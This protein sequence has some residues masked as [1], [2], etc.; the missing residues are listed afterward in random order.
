MYLPCKEFIEL[1][2]LSTI[3]NSFC[4]NECS[5]E[6]CDH[7]AWQIKFNNDLHIHIYIHIY[8]KCNFSVNKKVCISLNTTS[9]NHSTYYQHHMHYS[10]RRR[11]R[12]KLWKVSSVAG[13]G[14]FRLVS[15]LTDEC[16]SLAYRH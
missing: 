10:C 16:E 12:Y 4:N 3:N 14:R 8:V 1:Y 6:S 9:M 7:S 15:S 2:R 11:R 13:E 5:G